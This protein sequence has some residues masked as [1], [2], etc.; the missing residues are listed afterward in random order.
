MPH[1]VK[2]GWEQ[3]WIYLHTA[4]VLAAEGLHPLPY[5]IDKRQVTIYK[6]AQSRPI[7][8]ECLRA[9]RWEGTPCCLNW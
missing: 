7:L 8:L 6:P 4:D 5:Y 1:K 9:E 2:R 3:Q